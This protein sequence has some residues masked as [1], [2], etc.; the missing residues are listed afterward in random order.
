MAIMECGKGIWD[1]ILEFIKI[2]SPLFSGV[3]VGCFSYLAHKYNRETT[4]KNT[5]IQND[6]DLNVQKENQTFEERKRILEYKKDLVIHVVKELEPIYSNSLALIK[7]YYSICSSKAP[8]DKNTFDLLIKNRFFNIDEYEFEVEIQR[9]LSRASA[10]ISLIADFD[11]SEEMINLENAMN[12]SISVVEFDDTNWNE[13]HSKK[14][15]KIMQD[16]QGAY[17][18]LFI[19]IGSSL[20]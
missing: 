18:L 6:K 20:T 17:T 13:G 7:S 3:L 12:S 14:V 1:L 10:Y 2:L 4:L 16:L 19:K 15:L 5:K 8:F 9:G 11:I